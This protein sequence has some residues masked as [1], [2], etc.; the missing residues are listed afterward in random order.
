MT[1]LEL[2]WEYQKADVAVD[3]MQNNIKHS[4]T[5]AKL[6]KCHDNLE[7]QQKN[8]KRIENEISMMADRLEALKDAMSHVDQQM[9]T[10]QKK[11]EENPPSDSKEA[12]AYIAEARKLSDDIAGYEKEISKIRKDASDRDRLQ[13]DV[14]VRFA[15]YKSE[16]TALKEVYDAEYKK[17]LA[18]LDGLKAEAKEKE[19][20]ISAELLEKY[21]LI[22]KHS[23]PPLSKLSGDKCSGCNM[24]LPSG[25]VRSIK[26]GEFVE[27]ENCG[28]LVML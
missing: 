22:K 20:G 5:R 15:K 23:V 4:A 27:C 1:E 16:F 10:L 2:L 25:A 28:R 21:A 26:N 6:V 17:S 18:E 3:R 11:I 7:E 14:K 12:D 9:K 24:N 8:Y 13:H 19:K